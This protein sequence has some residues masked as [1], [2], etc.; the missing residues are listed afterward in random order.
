[1]Q[2][3]PATRKLPALPLGATMSASTSARIVLPVLPVLAALALLGP[4]SAT[5]TA[6]QVI[7]KAGAVELTESDV[8]RIVTALPVDARA[9]VATNDSALE[10]LVRSELVRRMMVG[11]MKKQDFDRDPAALA[12]LERLREDALLRLWIERNS[13]VPDGYPS[14]AEVAS[15]YEAAKA[16]Q[17][18]TVEYRLSQIFVSLPDGAPATRVTEALKKAADLQARVTAGDFAALARQYSEHADS[19]QKGGDLGLMPESNLIPEVRAAV[20]GIPVGTVV[21]PLKTAQGLH[22]VKVIERKPVPPPPLADVRD[23]LVVALRQQ[24][25]AELQREYLAKLGEGTSISV[26]QVELGKLRAALK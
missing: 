21:G 2:P 16:R 10:Q 8:R 23:R 26:N 12:E 11:E 24:K 25:A 3:Q 14:A 5:P 18:D 7:A 20:T 17:G 6:A 1:M 22:F 4:W 13:R 15:A 19:A 9:A